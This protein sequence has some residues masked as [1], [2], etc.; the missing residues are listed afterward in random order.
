MLYTL[1]PAEN[2]VRKGG[3]VFI[4]I[5]YSEFCPLQKGKAHLAGSH[6]PCVCDN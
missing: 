5:I 3:E 2:M 6:S 4:F 1:P